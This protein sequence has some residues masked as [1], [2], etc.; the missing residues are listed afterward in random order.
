MELLKRVSLSKNALTILR[1]RYLKRDIQGH[2]V[3]TPEEMF[4]RVA[5]TVAEVEKKFVPKA[6]VSALAEDFYMLMASLDF[7]PNSPTLMNAGRDLGQLSACF[8]LPVEDS[9]ES[10]FET[11]K[12]TAIIHKSGGGT[13][14]SFSR[15]R[16]RGDLVRSTLGV[17][18]GP[19]SFIAV[20]DAAT[21][22]IKQGGTRRG[23]NMAVLR[24]DHPDIEEFI[25]AKKAPE[26]FKNFNFSVGVTG[27][28][29]EALKGLRDF[30]LINPRDQQPLR[31][32]SATELF[33][34]LA[35]SAWLS[36][37]PG[38][39]FLDHINAANPTPNLGVLEATNPCGEVPLLPFES[40]NLGSINLAHF[41]RNGAV[42]YDRLG[43]V[44]HR[45]VHF[46]DN[47][48]EANR[49]PLSQI[50]KATK[51]TRKIGLGVMGFADL[52]IELG[53]SYDSEAAEALAEEVM[54]F[55]CEE[56]IKASAELARK[57]GNFPAYEGSIWDRPETP[58]MRNATTT[59]IAPTGSISIIAGCSSGIEP[60]FSVAYTRRV[61]EGEE[62]WEVHPLF[63]EKLKQY[64]FSEEKIR[65]FLKIAAQKGSIQGITEIPSAVRRLF[66]TT[67][68]IAPQRHL[69]I[70]AAFQRHVHNA[71]S[72]TINFPP[73]ARVEE[74]KKAYLLAHELG[75]KG[76]TIYRY[77]SKP[78]QV[79]NLAEEF[80]CACLARQQTSGTPSRG[81]Y[82][83][84]GDVNISI[85]LEREGANVLDIH[86]KLTREHT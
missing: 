84:L 58:F 50:E 4:W 68:D 61:L 71:V 62:L 33:S 46:L 18:S 10:I 1:K 43:Q 26:R 8:V 2:P 51:R 76:V 69:R 65:D 80:E 27:A 9:L 79:L 5:W 29:M 42:D 48:I 41:V 70:Q 64:G 72:K 34:L 49:Y 78:E 13:G 30:V 17:S 59:T 81:I 35:E 11:L 25:T 23:A 14:F 44:V 31:R 83:R 21:E 20:Y 7:L 75:L 47:V 28:F 67:F 19:V 45:A 16:P 60:L 73:Q 40:C 22:A 55:I 32:V 66:V 63:R 54:Q 38:V 37:D 56:S 77:G 86:I 74:V 57:R 52:L 3:E 85:D 6:Q 12:H 82:S 36:G 15:L 39:L 24:I 53:V